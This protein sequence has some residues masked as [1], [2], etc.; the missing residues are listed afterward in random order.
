MAESRVQFH[1]D[2]EKGDA[3]PIWTTLRPS[4]TISWA[5]LSAPTITER[6]DKNLCAA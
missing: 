4:Y 1:S 6:I 5:R 2:P 3:F